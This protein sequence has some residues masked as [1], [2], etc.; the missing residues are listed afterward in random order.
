[1]HTLVV[2]AH[3]K[4]DSYT[5]AVL[6][7]LLAGL[8][9]NTDDTVEVADLYREGFDP[10]FQ[11]DDYAQFRGESMPPAIGREQER[12]A[13]AEALAFVFPVW[14]WS[15]PAMLKG[16]IDRVFSEGWAYSFEPGISRG[17]LRDRP[18]LLLGIGGSREATYRKYGYNEAMRVQMDI[19]VLGYC[20]L[21]D[22]EMQV[23][24]DVEQSPENRARYLIEAW[25]TG[26]RFLSPM[27]KP[28]IPEMSSDRVA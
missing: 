5:G 24:Y 7:A 4:R 28:R 12:V 3:P 26:R 9:E 15:F 13:R 23:F 22:V 2:F 19:G 21:R 20:G 8:R 6:D 10:C 17:R 25:E 27:R 11:P 16:W 14:W 1:M 18:T